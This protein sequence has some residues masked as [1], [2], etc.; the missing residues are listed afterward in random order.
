MQFCLRLSCCGRPGDVHFL[1]A[2]RDG[3]RE[4][5]IMRRMGW[6]RQG[7]RE[8]EK[9]GVDIKRGKWIGKLFCSRSWSFESGISQSNYHVWFPYKTRCHIF[10]FSFCSFLI[11]FWCFTLVNIVW[12]YITWKCWLFTGWPSSDVIKGLALCAL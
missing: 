6:E 5:Q 8:R 4:D 3:G 11:I 2:M 7:K 1:Y 9:E 10:H 12:Y